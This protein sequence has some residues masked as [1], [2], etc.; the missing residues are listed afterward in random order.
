MLLFDLLDYII[1][2]L[3]RLIPILITIT[4]IFIAYYFYKLN[5]NSISNIEKFN[6][7]NLINIK[8]LCTERPNLCDNFIYKKYLKENKKYEE[9]NYFCGRE[10]YLNKNNECIFK[11]NEENNFKCPEIMCKNKSF[12][13]NK[14]IEAFQNTNNLKK[15]FCFQNNKC[16]AKNKNFMNPSKNTCCSPNISQYPNKIYSSFNECYNDNLSFKDIPKN[17]CLSL[18]HGYGYI[19][20]YGCVKGTPTGPDNI[21]LDYGIYSDE[22][23]YTP[24][25]P[26]PY[27]N[28]NYRYNKYIYSNHL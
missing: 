13:K 19:D 3:I 17:L 27:I 14:T 1:F 23:N 8:K 26:N 9:D 18:P 7:N 25:N 12:C 15:Y 11:L 10:C 21:F 20:G 5:S 6:N 22:Q 2:L 24:S 16:V 4:S 28:Y